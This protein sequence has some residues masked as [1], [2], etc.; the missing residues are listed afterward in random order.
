[1]LE[2]YY[3][4]CISVQSP[5]PRPGLYSSLCYYLCMFVMPYLTKYSKC[6]QNLLL[7]HRFIVVQKWLVYSYEL[8]CQ[9]KLPSIFLSKIAKF[10]STVCVVLPPNIIYLLMPRFIMSIPDLKSNCVVAIQYI[11]A[12]YSHFN[13]YYSL[14][15]GWGVYGSASEDEKKLTLI[16]LYRLIV[17][18]HAAL[19]NNTI[20]SVL[21]KCAIECMQVLVDA[22][23]P[24]G[25][26]PPMDKVKQEFE[27]RWDN[28]QPSP[29]NVHSTKL[30]PNMTTLARLVAR[31]DHDTWVYTE[32][33]NG[34]LY[35]DV[36]D[37]NG[38]KNPKM[39]DF[40]DLMKEDEDRYLEP[41]LRV[42]KVL[43]EFGWKLMKQ[44]SHSVKL[45]YK[46]PLVCYFPKSKNFVPSPLNLSK[47]HLDS[48]AYALAE[49]LTSEAYDKANAAKLSC[50][51]GCSS[52]IP[53]DL[54]RESDKEQKR[55]YFVNFMKIMKAHNF[56]V[57][58]ARTTTTSSS[59]SKYKSMQTFGV[60][61]ITF[62]LNCLETIEGK[63]NML[64]TVYAPLVH[65]YLC[66]Y[67]DYFLPDQITRN[68][69]DHSE[70]VLVIKLFCKM[71]AIC[72]KYLLE[73]VPRENLDKDCSITRNNV[74]VIVDCLGKICAVINPKFMSSRSKNQ[75]VTSFES[76]SNFLENA[77]QC[78]AD[79]FQNVNSLSPVQFEFGFKILIP[80]LSM[81][82]QH[83]GS[84][85]FGHYIMHKNDVTFGHCKTIFFNLVKL[86]NAF[87]PIHIVG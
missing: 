7:A 71:F 36:F 55:Q 75:N 56:E 12:H 14:S 20:D 54:L 74:K 9:P 33:G 16:M 62:I 42:V 66:H 3:V 53:Y 63:M 10:L 38:R 77:G 30:D 34:W 50:T 24:E 4:V 40:G 29:A 41:T 49:K 59:D 68:T 85:K 52:C 47:I 23:P 21:L 86:S 48:K 6:L 58:K 76:L 26:F 2:V 61:L 27:S 46:P 51:D 11:I 81:L 80:C 45:E 60:E 70:D 32:M 15:G 35:G 78:L 31:H 87:S 79:L 44:K 13:R 84:H 57:S 5:D 8:S 37:E 1:M 67:H 28:Y 73:L 72:Q 43:S 17:A 83:F 19:A 18:L 64:V 65:S 82:F 22:L 39:V 25:L 69:H